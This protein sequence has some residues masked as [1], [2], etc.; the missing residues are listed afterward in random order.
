M[1]GVKLEILGSITEKPPRPTLIAPFLFVL[2]SSES[3][4]TYDV[5]IDFVIYFCFFERD[6]IVVASE[7][8]TSRRDVQFEI[9]QRY[10]QRMNK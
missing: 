5:Y 10:A 6:H 9:S 1:H 4:C 7:R 8:P 2:R 3:L